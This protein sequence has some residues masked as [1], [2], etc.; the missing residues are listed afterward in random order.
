VAAGADFVDT[1][2]TAGDPFRL[3]SRAA[4][5]LNRHPAATRAAQAM[6]SPLRRG[7]ARHPS[8]NRRSGSSAR[9]VSVIRYLRRVS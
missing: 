8:D 9:R 7:I 4:G 2:T 1:D 3:R 6:I 5:A